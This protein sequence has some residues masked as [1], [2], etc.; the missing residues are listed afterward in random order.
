MVVQCVELL[1]HSSMVPG[2]VL[3][4]GYCMYSIGFHMLFPCLW[5]SSASSGF[6]LKD[7]PVGG[8]ATKL[9]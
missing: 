7:T 4:L 5:V 8:L 3:N 9:P 2:S 1:P 6:L